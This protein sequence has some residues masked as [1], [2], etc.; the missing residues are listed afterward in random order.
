MKLTQKFNLRSIRPMEGGLSGFW[1][2]IQPT[3]VANAI[4][5]GTGPGVADDSGTPT[6]GTV[7]PGHFIYL[8]GATADF[9]PSVDLTAAGAAKRALVAFVVFSGDDDFSGSFVGEVLAV[10]GPG[11]LDTEQYDAGSY[12]PSDP[13]I[14]SATNPGNLAPKTTGDHK[15]VIAQ[16]GP[17]GTNNGVMDVI[18]IQ[19]V[20]SQDF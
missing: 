12:S 11:R 16:V 20:N 15:Q 14:A 2:S 19:G 3:E 18:F 10:H 5:A 9:L 13:L 17:R 1:I 6:P 4:N 7:K 8:S